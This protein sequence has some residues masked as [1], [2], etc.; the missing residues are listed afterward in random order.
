[1]VHLSILARTSLCAFLEAARSAVCLS[2]VLLLLVAIESITMPITQG[3]W[4]WDKFLHGGQDFE[5]GLLII[6]TCLCFVLLRVQQNRTCFGWLALIWAF[7]PSARKQTA[8]SFLGLSRSF[9]H[10]SQIPSLVRAS[11]FN[12]PLLI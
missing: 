2:R 4:S 10:R 3:V 11:V 6:V 5:L 9:Q 12:L 7:S 8:A 1:V